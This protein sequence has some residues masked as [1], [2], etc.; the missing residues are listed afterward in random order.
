MV[1]SRGI[2]SGESSLV[3]PLWWSEVSGISP[4]W[5]RIGLRAGPCR[6][7]AMISLIGVCLC[8]RVCRNGSLV[9]GLHPCRMLLYHFK[10]TH[11]F[12]NQE[13]LMELGNDCWPMINVHGLASAVFHLQCY[14]RGVK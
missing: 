10:I 1:V 6:G 2:L 9:D 12:K 13:I 14:L 4:V 7:A 3:N 8:W 5:Q 11:L